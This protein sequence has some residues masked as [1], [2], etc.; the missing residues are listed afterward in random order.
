MKNSTNMKSFAIEWIGK[1]LTGV[2]QVEHADLMLIQ[3][4][5][6]PLPCKWIIFAGNFA[7]QNGI[8]ID[9]S[10]CYVVTNVYHYFVT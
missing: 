10:S 5:F 7:Y 3:L 8:N 2:A 1:L 6:A 4:R 9:C